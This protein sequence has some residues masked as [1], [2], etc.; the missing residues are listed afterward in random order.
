M[1]LFYYKLRLE[2]RCLTSS[3]KQL[4]AGQTPS[5]LPLEIGP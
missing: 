5:I 4:K 2:E 1:T 3:V